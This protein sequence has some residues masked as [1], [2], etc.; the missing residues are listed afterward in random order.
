MA[1]FKSFDNAAIVIVGIERVHRIQI[2]HDGWSGDRA[3]DR[4]CGAI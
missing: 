4:T 2:R 3:G 1:G